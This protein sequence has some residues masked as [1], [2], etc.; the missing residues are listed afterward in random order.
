[1][2]F[3]H[4]KSYRILVADDE[5]AI[6]DVYRKIFTPAQNPSI[7]DSGMEELENKLFGEKADD[8][9]LL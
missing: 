5:Q 6:L 4:P 3:L 7:I 9:H 2:D 1:M 8:K